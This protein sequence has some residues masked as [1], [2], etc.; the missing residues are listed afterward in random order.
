MGL[1]GVENLVHVELFGD[2]TI[3]LVQEGDEV[4]A[5]LGVADVGDH[6]PDRDVEGAQRSQVPLCW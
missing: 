2:L 3:E 6:R 4:C 1:E 5:G